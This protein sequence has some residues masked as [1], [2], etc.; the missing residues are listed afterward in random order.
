[1]DLICVG[2]RVINLAL[3]THADLDA[4]TPDVS[5]VRLHLAVP[6]EGGQAWVDFTGDEAAALRAHLVSAAFDLTPATPDDREYAEFRRRGGD[7][8]RAD[9]DGL[10]ESLRS[11]VDRGGE[12]TQRDFDRAAAIEAQLLV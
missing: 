10:R 2:G 9:W 6:S 3:V 1:M 11:M 5:A 8:P 7:M 12:W 4:G